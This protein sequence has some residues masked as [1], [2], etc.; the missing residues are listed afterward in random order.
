M[1]PAI[2]DATIP[3]NDVMHNTQWVPGHFH[4]YLLLGMIAMLLGFMTYVGGKTRNDLA[5]IG[6]W[7]YL[8]G[9]AIFVLAFLFGGAASVPRRYAVHLAGWIPYDRMGYIGASIVVMGA[10][11]VVVQFLWNFRNAIRTSL[12]A[13]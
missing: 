5:P 9:G 2:A 13:E 7:V 6:F 4:T 1:I 10:L 3:V 11:I 8:A 12:P